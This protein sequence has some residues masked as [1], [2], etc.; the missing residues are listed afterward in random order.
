MLKLF[1]YVIIVEVWRELTIIG[2]EPG[3]TRRDKMS[4]PTKSKPVFSVG[5]AYPLLV[6][7]WLLLLILGVMP[8]H[9][10]E[11]PLMTKAP[12]SVKLESRLARFTH[13]PVDPADPAAS[14]GPSRPRRADEAARPQ[15]LHVGLPVVRPAKGALKG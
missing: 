5:R 7:Y 4:F 6:L 3:S 2:F 1:K 12:H 9:P 10:V 11:V 8:M 14:C 15:Y 13:C